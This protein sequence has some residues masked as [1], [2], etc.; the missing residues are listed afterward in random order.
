MRGITLFAFD[1]AGCGQSEGQ[2]QNRGMFTLEA[3]R[4]VMHMF[5]AIWVIGRYGVALWFLLIFRC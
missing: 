5:N 3:Y 4:P 2:T 1:F